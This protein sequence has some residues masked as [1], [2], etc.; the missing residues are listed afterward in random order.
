MKANIAQ[1]LVE[2]VGCDILCE[3]VSWVV[4]GHNLVDCQDPIVHQLLCE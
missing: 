4:M 2:Y 1:V 3:D